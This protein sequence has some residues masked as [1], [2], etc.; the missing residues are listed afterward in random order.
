M[1]QKSNIVESSIKKIKMAL[2]TI[3]NQRFLEIC[4]TLKPNHFVLLLAYIK[5]SLEASPYGKSTGTLCPKDLRGISYLYPAELT[6]QETKG[7]I[8]GEA[9]TEI[10]KAMK[11]AIEDMKLQNDNKNKI[12][13]QTVGLDVLKQPEPGDVV[14]IKLTGPGNKLQLGKVVS[15]NKSTLKI[16]TA[17]TETGGNKIQDYRAEDCILIHRPPRDKNF[18]NK[19]GSLGFIV[20]TDSQDLIISRQ[21]DQ[22]Q[23]HT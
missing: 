17:K 12:Y 10:E 8:L 15:L 23:T 7:T 21:Q 13:Y 3:G 4:K 11:L 14:Q 16:K 5:S 22:H 18:K 6:L 1:G 19:G 2:E 20:L 9:R